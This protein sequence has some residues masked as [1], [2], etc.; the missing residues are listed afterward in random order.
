L[1]DASV[2]ERLHINTDS[3]EALM[4]QLQQSQPELDLMASALAT[5]R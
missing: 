4:T 1:F 2:Y 3:I 5:G